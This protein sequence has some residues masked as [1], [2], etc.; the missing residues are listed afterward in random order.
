VY[1]DGP[2][3]NTLSD[4]EIETITSRVK[5]IIHDVCKRLDAGNENLAADQI[6]RESRALFASEY[7][8]PVQCAEE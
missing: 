7:P 6:I 2:S 4:E 8:D 5:V 1:S 3:P